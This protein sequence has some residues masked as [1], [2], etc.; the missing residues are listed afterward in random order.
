MNKTNFGTYTFAADHA[1]TIL[2]AHE[3]AT[4]RPVCTRTTS[5]ESV[6]VPVTG[7]LTMRSST[8]RKTPAGYAEIKSRK[9]AEA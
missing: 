2:S 3:Y 8:E 4:L 5:G 7:Y 9:Y 6:S 1:G